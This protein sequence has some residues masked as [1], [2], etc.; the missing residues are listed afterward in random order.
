MYTAIPRAT[1][2]NVIQR[3]SQTYYIQIKMGY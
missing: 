2:E 3:Y 1:F